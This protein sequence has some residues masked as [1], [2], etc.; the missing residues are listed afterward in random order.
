MKPPC[1]RERVR[2]GA[3]EQLQTEQLHSHQA[4]QRPT[5]GL[6]VLLLRPGRPPPAARA[7]ASVGRAADGEGSFLPTGGSHLRGPPWRPSRGSDSHRPHCLAVRTGAG[8]QGSAELR[9]APRLPPPPAATEPP[10][11]LGRAVPGKCS[12]C[13]G[14]SE[15]GVS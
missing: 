12:Y 6:G 13:T 4:P 10:P 5:E 15:S 11:Q 2:R 14:F 3:T 8:P 9:G 7:P 1:S